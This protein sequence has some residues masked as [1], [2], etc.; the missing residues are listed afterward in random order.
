MQLLRR[1]APLRIDAVHLFVRLSVCLSPKCVHKN[2]IFSKT[3]Q[4]RAMDLGLYRWP[5]GSPTWAFQNPSLDP[6]NAVKYPYLKIIRFRWNLIQEHVWNSMTARWPN[7]NIL[8]IQDGGRPPFKNLFSCNSVANCPISVK[9][10]VLQSS[11]FYRILC[12]YEDLK[13]SN[14][15]FKSCWQFRFKFI[16]SLAAII[17][18]R[19]RRLLAV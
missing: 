15:V 13:A 2:A 9:F 4:F 19:T 7:M 1:A 6:W 18:Y 16:D 17:V 8:K 11:F 14:L 10:C 5:I 3:K 12:C